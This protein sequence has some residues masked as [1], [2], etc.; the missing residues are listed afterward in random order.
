MSLRCSLT[1]HDWGEKRVETQRDESDGEVVV[2][3]S[4]FRVCERCGERRVL[5]ENTEVR[6]FG[7]ETETGGG[8]A[9]TFAPSDEFT[10]EEDE[11]AAIIDGTLDRERDSDDDEE[12]QD[13]NPPDQDTEM[14]AELV[15][16]EKHEGG[17][18]GSADDV[19]ERVREATGTEV[20]RTETE[21]E[22]ETEEAPDADAD[23]VCPDCGFS[24]SDGSLRAGDI[25]PDCG[26]YIEEA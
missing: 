20:T 14:G 24:S 7:E 15:D 4:E 5:S 9:S 10:T 16:A 11:D 18:T 12:P 22:T 6:A 19:K 17:G 21:T 13:A 3:E 26:G 1:G 2:T 25:C 23:Y 8:E